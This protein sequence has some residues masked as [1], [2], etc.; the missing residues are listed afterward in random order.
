MRRSR[1]RT[2][3]AVAATVAGVGAL[4]LRLLESHRVY[5][6]GAAWV[7]VFAIVLLAGLVLAAGW[8]VRAYLRGDKP[9]LDALRA[10]RTFAMGKAAAYT[11]ALLAGRYAAH[12]L[13]VLPELE[14][15]A[16]LDQAIT[17]G[18]AAL[19]AVALSTAGVLVEKFCQIP[20]P[21]DD[22]GE[23]EAITS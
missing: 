16:R 6:P 2:L 10:A 15:E 3:V 5:L 18:V 7:E 4:V 9:D 23:A 21:E 17:S 12:V 22:D 19:A 1:V 14:V 20:P 11:G 13:V 8:S